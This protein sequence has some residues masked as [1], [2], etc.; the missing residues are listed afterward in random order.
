MFGDKPFLL[1]ASQHSERF[2]LMTDFFDFLSLDDDTLRLLYFNVKNELD[3]RDKL[4][5]PSLKAE[6]IKTKCNN[7]LV[8]PICKIPLVKNGKRNDGVQTYR[9]K[10]CG[11]RYSDTNNYS[12]SSSKLSLNEIK[13]LITLILIGS[14]DWAISQIMKINVKTAQ[15]WKDRCIDAA[16]EWANSNI[17]SDHVFIDEMFFSSSRSDRNFETIMTADDVH[18]RRIAMS[19]AFD[20]HGKGCCHVHM[21]SGIPSF[22]L[23]TSAFKNKIKPG[24]LITHDQAY[25]YRK[26]IEKLNLIDEPIKFDKSNDSIYRTKLKLL[27]NCCSTLRYNFSCHRGIKLAKLES[28]GNLFIYRWC[29]IRK[30]GFKETVEDMYNRVCVAKKS[31]KFR[32]SFK[33]DSKW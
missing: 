27:N 23:I 7:E 26:L 16:N 18:A 17:L 25:Y 14:P 31:H 3:R 15:Y 8:C 12:L 9:C 19:I 33:K 6:I 1:D 10:C 5:Q 21:K 32:D 28:Y 11:K 13:N 2:F 30:I 20:I 24:S 4:K 22:N 29:S